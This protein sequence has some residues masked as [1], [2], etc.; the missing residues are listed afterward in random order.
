MGKITHKSVGVVFMVEALRAALTVNTPVMSGRNSGRGGHKL[1]ST[2]PTAKGSVARLQVYNTERRI[3]VEEIRRLLALIVF[4]STVGSHF[5]GDCG[6]IS[7]STG[8]GRVGTV[9][10]AT[11]ATYAFGFSEAS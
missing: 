9:L 5:F 11:D 2:D 6:F 8:Y 7:S 4:S 3:C 1:V 10:R